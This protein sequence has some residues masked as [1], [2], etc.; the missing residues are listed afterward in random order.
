MNV[1]GC[2][3]VCVCVC[4]WGGGGG[5]GGGGGQSVKNRNLLPLAEPA[6][7]PRERESLF[8]AERMNVNKDGNWR[9]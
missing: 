3:C 4:V 8:V 6:L 7:T 9:N 2:V 1:C 5:G